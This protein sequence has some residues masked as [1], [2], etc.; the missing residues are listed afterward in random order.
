M[1]TT[2]DAQNMVL[3]AYLKKAT[4][5]QIASVIRKDWGTKIYFGAKPYLNAMFYVMGMN[6]LYGVENGRHQVMYFLSNATMWRGSTA[7]LV[8]AEL[9]KRLKASR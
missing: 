6:D 4:L 5:D 8:K 2:I 7:R 9:N 1:T 3:E